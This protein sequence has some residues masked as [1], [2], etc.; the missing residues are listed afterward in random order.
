MNYKSRTTMMLYLNK[1]GNFSFDARIEAKVAEYLINTMKNGSVK[2]SGR[3]RVQLDT[4]ES[5][6][7]D[8]DI[9]PAFKAYNKDQLR[10][11]LYTI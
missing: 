6:W 9:R 3:C 1:K 8:S 4:F 2:S 7:E 5:E 10:A 11:C